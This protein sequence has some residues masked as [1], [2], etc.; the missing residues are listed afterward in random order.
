MLLVPIK[1]LSETI[2]FLLIAT[3]TFYNFKKPQGPGQN[4]F[5]IVANPLTLY[6]VYND[7]KTMKPK[8]FVL[9][10]CNLGG[11][12][13]VVGGFNA[14]SI[15]SVCAHL[16]LNSIVPTTVVSFLVVQGISGQ[17]VRISD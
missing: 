16:G 4:P 13:F 15:K 17:L 5:I 1:W 3:S 8:W 10:S 6:S 2:F 7:D 9:C 14:R 12:F 11:F